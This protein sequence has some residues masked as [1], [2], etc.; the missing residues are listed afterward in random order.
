MHDASCIG[1]NYAHRF[2]KCVK[3]LHTLLGF[4]LCTSCHQLGCCCCT[5]LFNFWPTRQFL[6]EIHT[7]KT[8]LLRCCLYTT[9]RLQQTSVSC[10]RSYCNK[11]KIESR[12][13]EV[14]SK[15]GKQ[16]VFPF[17]HV[18]L[19]VSSFIDFL[20][21]IMNSTRNHSIATNWRK[22]SMIGAI[23][24]TSRKALACSPDF[25]V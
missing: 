21:I 8:G 25:L 16:R 18:A 20:W 24:D 22:N 14:L 19:R 12:T 17:Y 11:I 3:S 13:S 23:A 10:K 15:D 9:R 5:N 1:I 6:V 2:P 7:A 4:S